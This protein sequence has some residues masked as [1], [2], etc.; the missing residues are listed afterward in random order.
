MGSNVPIFLSIVNKFHYFIMNFDRP[1]SIIAFGGK[2]KQLFFRWQLEFYPK[3][4]FQFVNCYISSTLVNSKMFE[5]LNKVRYGIKMTNIH[6]KC[7]IYGQ[8]T[9]PPFLIYEFLE[10]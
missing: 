8:Q 1:T 9:W 10:P 2:M 7:H 6:W 3:L 4:F 5:T